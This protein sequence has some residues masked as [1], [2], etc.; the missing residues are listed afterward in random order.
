MD[1]CDFSFEELVDFHE[2]RAADPSGMREHLRE[3]CS[4]CA[5]RLEWLRLYLPAVRSALGPEHGPS[6]AALAFVRNLARTPAAVSP[7]P[8]VLFTLARLVFDGRSGPAAGTRRTGGEAFHRLYETDEHSITLW[9]EP[10]SGAS[11]VIGQAYS[12]PDGEP[13]TPQSVVGS[14]SEGVSWSAEIQGQEFHFAS[15]SP[16]AYDLHLFLGE[17]EVRLVE[18]EIGN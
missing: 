13:L 8:A 7:G 2:G 12:R 9:E 3:G 5:E 6:P 10:A 4:R 1:T 14:S 17:A 16:G 11:Y 18:V 15:L